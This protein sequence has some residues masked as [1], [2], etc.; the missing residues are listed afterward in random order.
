MDCLQAHVFL[1]YSNPMAAPSVPTRE[2]AELTD[3][4]DEEQFELHPILVAGHCWCNIMSMTFHV[5]IKDD[6]TPIVINGHGLELGVN[7][8]YVS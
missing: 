6:D 5:W 3:E 8:T 1:M 4:L 2:S 7:V